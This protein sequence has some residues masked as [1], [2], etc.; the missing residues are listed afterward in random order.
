MNSKVTLYYDTKLHHNK[1]FIVDDIIS[2]L[3]TKTSTVVNDVQYQRFDLFKRLKLNLSQAFQGN[4]YDVHKWD[5]CEIKTS[6]GA[7]D[8]IYYYF[9]NGYRQVA[10][11]TIELDLEMDVLNT[12]RY[13]T[14]GVLEYERNRVYTLSPKSLITREHKDRIKKSKMYFAYS[15]IPTPGSGFYTIGISNFDVTIN[16][17]A[18]F[19]FIDDNGKVLETYSFNRIEI[20]D[21]DYPLLYKT[22]KLYLNNVV[23]YSSSTPN[24]TSYKFNDATILLEISSDSYSTLLSGR[25]FFQGKYVPKLLRIID[26][27]QE[28]VETYL[29]K[30]R[31]EQLLDDDRLTTTYVIYKSANVPASQDATEPLYIN[32]IRIG[33]CKDEDIIINSRLASQIT[34]YANNVNIPKIKNQKEALVI[35]KD[36]LV[37]GAYVNIG[38]TQYDSNDFPNGKNCIVA[39]RKNNNDITFNTVDFAEKNWNSSQGFYVLENPQNIAAHIDA[40]TFY[41]V[42]K[43]ELWYGAIIYYDNSYYSSL[44]RGEFYIGSNANDDQKLVYKWKDRDLTNPQLIKAINFPYRPCDFLK[45]DI[46]GYSPLYSFNDTDHILELVNAQD[47]DFDRQIYFDADNPLSIYLLDRQYQDGEERNDIFE[48]K[49]YHSDYY[50]PK[51]VYDSFGF[52]YYL[53]NI[54]IDSYLDSFNLEDFIVRYVISANVLSKF[55]FQ[56]IQYV[57]FRSTQDYE[58]V[59]IVDRNNEKAL[60]NNAYVNYIKSGGYSYDTKKANSQNAINGITTALSIVGAVA[61]FSTGSAFGIVGGIGLATSGAASIIRNI[62]TAQEQD[63]SISQKL[64]QLSNQATQVQGSE[65]VDLL[66]A[67]SDNKAK[68]VYYEPSD[69]MKKAILDLFYYCGYATH[70]QKVPDP[71]TRRYF[72][73]IQGEIILDHYTFNEDVAE[74][75][76]DKWKE[77]VTFIHRLNYYWDVDQVKENIEMS[78]F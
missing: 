74:K 22:L 53:E 54:D 45:N 48:S 20:F 76:K 29:F 66:K 36:T 60:Y 30:K 6:D 41:G 63:K 26:T 17:I 15:G 40:I 56:F 8:S 67:F 72:N 19:N 51:F 58:N 68:M 12:F 50:Q 1:N 28:G 69:V 3:A 46:D 59:L 14:D 32:P 65:D 38:G 4:L 47:N 62:H 16:D 43:C 39:I 31:E 57:T 52:T 5:Y 75:I 13:D 21:N 37:N 24:C 10:Q 78:I 42:E 35:L 25:V 11:S 61:S 2:Y 49:I 7:S 23:V 33:V 18:K 73:F 71:K 55:I 44:P 9:I 27:F 70:E 77:G 64:M 34:I